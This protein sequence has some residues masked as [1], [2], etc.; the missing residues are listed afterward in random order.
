V[1]IAHP[2]ARH[3]TICQPLVE[4]KE[5]VMFLTG[6]VACTVTGTRNMWPRELWG[7]QG[8]SKAL[9]LQNTIWI[10][11]QYK[12]SLTF[13]HNVYDTLKIQQHDN[14]PTIG[15]APDRKYNRAFRCRRDAHSSSACMLL[16]QIFI[17]SLRSVFTANPKLPCL[18]ML[19]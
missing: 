17:T 4:R 16:L 1:T 6:G 11:R 14:L 12:G 7:N 9:P 13:Y 3:V 5:E 18:W 10:D 15:R 2:Q 8:Y 19:L